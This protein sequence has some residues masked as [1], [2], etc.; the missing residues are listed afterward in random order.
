MKSSAFWRAAVLFIGLATGFVGPATAWKLMPEATAAERGL[1]AVRASWLRNL[2]N[3]G[4]FKAVAVVGDPVHEGI[5]ERALKCPQ[6]GEGD[7]FPGCKFDIRYELAGVRWNDDPAILFKPEYG[8]H[9]GCKPGETVRMVTQ[10][11]C[12]VNVFLG[13]EA[14]ARGGKRFDGTNSNLLLRSHF[15]DLQFLHAMAAADGEAPTQTRAKVLAWL[16]FTWRT[17]IGEKGFDAQRVVAKLPISGFSQRFKSNRG[18]RIQDLFALGNEMARS[19]DAVQSIAFGSLM[20][21]VQDSFAAGH[22]DRAVP[23]AGSFCANRMGWPAPGPIVEFHSY[24]HQDSSKHGHD[25]APA[26]L[27]AHIAMAPNVIDVMRTLNDLWRAG[28]P[29]D[30]VLLYLDCVFALAPDARPSS[31]GKAYFMPGDNV[32]WG[33]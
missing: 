7:V 19:P 31:P 2:V 22:V 24:P 17:A 10:P 4:A 21:V 12:W 11:V 29:W 25:D 3:K 1:A 15:G 26:A 32:Q 30:E 5:T 6:P 33:G 16:E 20:H 13:G 28:A 18:W 9:F 27:E 23:Q 14:A 8:R